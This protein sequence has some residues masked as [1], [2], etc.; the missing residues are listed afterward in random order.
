M[1]QSIQSFS[2][3]ADLNTGVKLAVEAVCANPDDAQR[4]NGALKGIIGMGRLSTSEKDR[5]MLRFYDAIQVAS[6]QNTV[7]VNAEFTEEVLDTLM[8]LVGPGRGAT[9]SPELPHPN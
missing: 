1:V 7:R 8:G 4:I 9:S 3:G 6:E 2:G 5:D